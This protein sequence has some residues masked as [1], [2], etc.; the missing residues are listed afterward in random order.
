MKKQIY[1]L[2]YVLSGLFVLFI[3][4]AA[5]CEPEDIVSEA[6]EPI[7]EL[8][9]QSVAETDDSLSTESELP[10]QPQSAG[11]SRGQMIRSSIIIVLMLGVLIGVNVFL[12]KKTGTLKSFGGVRIKVL[13]RRG[14]DTKK[15]L[16]LI[17]VDGKKLLI[18]IGPQQIETLCEFNDDV[19]SPDE[20]T[21]TCQIGDKQ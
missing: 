11:I 14:I 21:N 12:K 18:G 1:I 5:F 3:M 10:D 4:D 15:A 19:N 6:S 9:E 8:S 16:F 13:E 17:S 20:R 2:R 7:A